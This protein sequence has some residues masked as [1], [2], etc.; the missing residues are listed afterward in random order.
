MLAE[1]LV[2]VH[3]HTYALQCNWKVPLSHVWIVR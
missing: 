1:G 3:S 2:H